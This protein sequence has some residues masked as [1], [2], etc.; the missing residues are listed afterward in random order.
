MPMKE[1]VKE[2]FIRVA[3]VSLIFGAVGVGIM[4]MWPQL[5]RQR[6]LCGQLAEIDRQLAE[7]RKEIDDLRENCRRFR[8]D[9]EFVEAIARENRR[10]LPGEYVFI[11]QGD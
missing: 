6:A 11:F 3:T 9:G 7:K 4:A 2:N 1:G 10:V 8:S 5:M